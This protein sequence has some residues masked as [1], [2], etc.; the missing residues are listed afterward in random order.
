MALVLA[1]M[2]RALVSHINATVKLYHRLGAHGSL[3]LRPSYQTAH[4][5]FLK[6]LQLSRLAPPTSSPGPLHPEWTGS[7][8]QL[9]VHVL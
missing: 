3:P 1:I 6:Q 5:C 8:Q 4:R 7:G 2:S 9:I